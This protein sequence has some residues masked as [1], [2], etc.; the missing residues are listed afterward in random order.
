MRL[1]SDENVHFVYYS[2]AT[3]MPTVDPS[4]MD[5]SDMSQ[6]DIKTPDAPDE[7]LGK[8]DCY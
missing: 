2:D 1:L 8:V 4:L 6:Y 3:Y 5:T 7:N